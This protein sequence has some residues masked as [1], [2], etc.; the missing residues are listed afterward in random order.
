ML[1]VLA[2]F[3]LA[4]AFTGAAAAL[5]VTVSAGCMSGCTGITV[6]IGKPVTVQNQLLVT[7]PVTI[8]C[9]PLTNGFGFGDISVTVEQ[10][11]RNSVSHGSGF[12]RRY[13]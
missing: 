9:L 7:V 2:R 8:T 11:N 6:V 10:A 1:K 5:P 13:A 3:A 12:V 4:A